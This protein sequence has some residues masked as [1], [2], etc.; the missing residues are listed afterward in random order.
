MV[1]RIRI[2]VT[3]YVHWLSLFLFCLLLRLV[4][5]VTR[6]W[7]RLHGEELYDR[8][9]HQILIGASK[10]EEWDELGM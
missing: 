1:A 3:L 4:Y 7:T 9:P 2:N 5:E 10:Q 8:T 6:E